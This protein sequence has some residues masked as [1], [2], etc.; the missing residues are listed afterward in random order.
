M[1]YKIFIVPN[2]GEKLVC[3]LNKPIYGL[4]QAYRQWFLKLSSALS[5]HGFIQSKSNY[6]LFTCGNSTK[7]MALQ[8]YVDDILLTGPSLEEINVVKEILK[9]HFKLKDL[10]QAKYFLGLELSCF[11]QGLL[12][13]NTSTHYRSSKALVI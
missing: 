5:A 6:S 10:G 7:F 2:K 11:K 13:H 8:V 12:F 3:Q 9:S 1:G 4:K